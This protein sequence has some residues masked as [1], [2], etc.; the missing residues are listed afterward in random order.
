MPKG[1]GRDSLLEK[2]GTDLTKHYQAALTKLGKEKG[3]LGNIFAGALSKF[4]EPAGLLPGLCAAA[5]GAPQR[6]ALCGA[7][8]RFESGE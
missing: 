5:G 7:P 1:Y 4:R 8:R 3:L 6:H 2:S